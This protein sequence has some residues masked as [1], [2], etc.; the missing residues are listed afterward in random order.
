MTAEG[1]GDARIVASTWKASNRGDKPLGVIMSYS[2]YK[3]GRLLGQLAA[4]WQ[5]PARTSVVTMASG[6][7]SGLEEEDLEGL[8]FLD[9]RA[10]LT[11]DS[12]LFD[13]ARVFAARTNAAITPIRGCSALY[14]DM[15]ES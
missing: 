13:Y 4:S 5:L 7:F 6:V 2:V 14:F 8:T 10:V 11:I 15:Q 3:E 12:G 9:N 1:S